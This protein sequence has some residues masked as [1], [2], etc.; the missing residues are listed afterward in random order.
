MTV[1]DDTVDALISIRDA[2][3]AEGIIASDRRWKKSLKLV[4]A[5][6][7]LAGEKQTTPEDLA[8]LVGL[9][10]AGA[11]GPPQGR[12]ARGQARRPGGAQATEI[13]DAARE[14]ADKVASLKAGDRKA[15]IAQAAQALEQFQPA[16]RSW[17]SSPSR[18]AAGRRTSS[19]RPPPRSPR[20]TRSWPARSAP[21]SAF[22]RWGSS[23][24][25]ASFTTCPAG[26]STCTGRPESCPP[27]S[28]TIRPEGSS[29]TS[30]S[31]GS[32][33]ATVS[34]WASSWGRSWPSSWAAR[35]RLPTT[36]R[37]STTGPGSS[38]PSAGSCLPS[39]G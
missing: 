10:L 13:L 26:T 38:T 19:T 28:R 9:A 14:T 18:L 30:S 17:R 25:S 1:T 36:T 27:S 33:P 31:T 5:A 8:I 7:Y 39:R 3:K 15:Y 34:T 4:Q 24:C 16:G 11:Q 22:A 29:R 35:V 23:P 2:C 21:V 37:S 12:P 32:T 20:C 6:A